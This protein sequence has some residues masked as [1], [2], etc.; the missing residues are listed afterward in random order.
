MVAW[1]NSRIETIAGAAVILA[2]ASF[3]SK[4]LG[5]IRNRVLAGTFGAGDTLD[6]YFAAFRIPDAIFQF[7][8]LGA[9]SA[10]FI[11]VFVELMGRSRRALAHAEP[12]RNLNGTHTELDHWRVAASV[13][14][15]LLLILTV[16]AVLFIIFAPQLQRLI[17]PGFTGEKLAVTIQL[18]RIMALGPI[19]LGISAV[20]SG[21]LQ[22]YRRFVVYAFAPIFYNVGIIIGAVWFTKF[23]GVRGLAAGVVLGTILHLAIQAPAA[24][25][26]GFRWRGVLDL[27]SEAVRKIGWLSLPRVFG[28]AVTQLNL[29][30]IT[31][32]ASKLPAGSLSVFNLASDIQSVPIGLFAVS[33]AT[34]AF[35]AFSEFAAR[36]NHDKFR[37]SFSSTARLILFLTV[38]FA[39][40]LLLL[41]AQVTRVILGWGEFDWNDTIETADALAFFSLSLFAQALLPLLARAFYALKDTL[42]P[43]LAGSVGVVLNIVLALIF[44][45]SFGVAGLA[46]AFSL[47]MVANLIA[48]WLLLRARMGSLDEFSIITSTFKISA[49][50]L[51]LAIVVQATKYAMAAHVNMQT[52]WGIFAQGAVAGVLGL[53]VFL[54]VAL[55]MGSPEAE[56]IKNAFAK[57]LF[58]AKEARVVEIVE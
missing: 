23:W 16:F 20:F 48:L 14:N 13:L 41:R 38:P 7:V 2:G 31:I 51:A 27:K 12:M 5:L 28:L 45:E 43:L 10:G 55:A 57:R 17:A 18:A 42:S 34:A 39:V 9:L 21:V 11:P 35:P 40:L 44:R 49:A 25:Q 15:A 36:G 33:L 37:S 47:A 50:S 4:I 26:V 53:A 22:S 54:L 58:R 29:F 32:I 46:L 56:Q 24:R 19:F 3:A 1:I 30:A 8:V 52:G 6:A